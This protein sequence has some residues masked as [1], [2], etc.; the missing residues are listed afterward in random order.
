VQNSFEIILKWC[1]RCLRLAVIYQ[2]RAAGTSSCKR[3]EL[4]RA[5]AWGC[6]GFP[7]ADAWAATDSPALTLGAATDSPALTL[8]AATDSPAL[9]L[10]LWRSRD[11]GEE[12]FFEAPGI[13]AL[14]GVD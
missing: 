11:H 4:P 13:G 14:V 7:R 8:G 9:T 3:W 10:G 12:A 6:D 5:D 1:D 2:I